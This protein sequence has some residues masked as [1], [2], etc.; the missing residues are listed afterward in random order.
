[1][2]VMCMFWSS[3]TSFHKPGVISLLPT[4]AW[5]FFSYDSHI[6]QNPP[7]SICNYSILM[8]TISLWFYTVDTNNI[9]SLN[10]ALL[11]NALIFPAQNYF[12]IN[13]GRPWAHRKLF[14][15][16]CQR[17][18]AEWKRLLFM[19]GGKDAQCLANTSWMDVIYSRA[20]QCAKDECN[21]TTEVLWEKKAFT[22]TCYITAVSFY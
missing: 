2:S 6:D 3:G 13:F 19:W 21:K 7:F 10:R 14:G 16:Y 15:C 1:M 17:E 18:L 9:F 4:F 8:W 20:S 12:T 11:P 22:A 5:F